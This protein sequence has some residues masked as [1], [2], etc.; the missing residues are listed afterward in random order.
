[1]KTNTNRVIWIVIIIAIVAFWG[2]RHIKNKAKEKAENLEQERIE[3]ETKEKVSQLVKDSNA[4]DDW[5]GKL[6]DNKRIRTEKILTI[7]LERLWIGEQPILFTGSIEDISKLDDDNYLIY[8]ERSLFSSLKT[9]FI[10]TELAL[11]LKC[12]KI[13]IDNLLNE[14]PDL[15]SSYGFNNG[16]AVIAKINNI[17]SEYFRGE[18]GERE[19]IKIGEGECINIT[20][21]G[22]VKF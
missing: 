9:M 14:Q 20:Y 10:S 5:V 15:F 13:L 7:E 11:R 21:T 1:M 17:E 4:I 3:Q 8:V 18:E 6:S 19:E 22:R 16:I 2:N 12:D